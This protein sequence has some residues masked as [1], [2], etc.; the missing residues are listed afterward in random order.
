MKK[1]YIFE[2][3]MIVR[4][5]E[6]DLQGIVNNANYQHYMEH[7]RHQFL[8]TKGVSFIELHQRGIDAVVARLTIDFKTPLRSDDAFTS[9]LILKKEGIR[10]VF[11]QDIYRKSDGQCVI[12]GR[13]D[14]VCLVNG[15][16]A[17]CPELNEM[18]K[19]CFDSSL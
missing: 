3:P 11:F 15:R 16:L 9:C 8:L 17:D 10:Y 1:N 4:D 2:L 6:C 14:V 18:F 12:R 19:D 13:V 5:Y 7:T